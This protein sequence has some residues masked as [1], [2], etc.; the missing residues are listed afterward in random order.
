MG[1]FRVILAGP[2]SEIDE[3]SS[4]IIS[5][6][7][8][9]GSI[10]NKIEFETVPVEMAKKIIKG[11]ISFDGYPYLD[12][13]ERVRVLNWLSGL[14]NKGYNKVSGRGIWFVSYE[15]PIDVLSNDKF[16]TILYD[17]QKG[18]ASSSIP[19]SYDPAQDYKD[20]I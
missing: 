6:F 10:K 15:S 5:E 3:S 2:Q 16:D 11:E 19:F 14:E 9:N 8:Q 20:E 1:S 4:S 18:T 17:L 13:F 7:E 12:N